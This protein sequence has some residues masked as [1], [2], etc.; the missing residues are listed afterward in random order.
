M[1][2]ENYPSPALRCKCGS[3]TK[4]GNS[5]AMGIHSNCQVYAGKPADPA[6]PCAIFPGKLVAGKGW[7][8]AYVK[9]AG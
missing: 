7:C 6:G 1:T 2:Q 4:G 5:R 9:K 8:S 3:V